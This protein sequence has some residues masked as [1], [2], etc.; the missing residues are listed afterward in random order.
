M[1]HHYILTV[2]FTGYDNECC[3]Y[4]LVLL[5][6]FIFNLAGMYPLTGLN[7]GSLLLQW[8]NTYENQEEGG[9]GY[10]GLRFQRFWTVVL[11]S[12]VAGPVMSREDMIESSSY[13]DTNGRGKKVGGGE[14]TLRLVEGRRKR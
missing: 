10:C 13:L 11:G 2:S 12:A 7:L 6:S 3:Q 5:Y 1:K 4:Y 14:N 9:T 8:Q